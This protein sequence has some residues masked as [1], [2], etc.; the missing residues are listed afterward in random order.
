MVLASCMLVAACTGAPPEQTR[1]T[2]QTLTLGE[3]VY[4]TV[5]ENLET[6][7]ECSSEYTSQLSPHH[8][9]FVAALD[10]TLTHG[11]EGGV[12]NILGKTIQPSVANGSLPLLTDRVGEALGMLVS[13]DLDPERD[14]L[15]AMLSLASARTLFESS[16]IAS[17]ASAL[18][19]N[20]E[21]PERMHDLRR[22]AEEHDG[23]DYVLADIL[24]LA[25]PQDD[26]PPLT[27]GGINLDDVQGTLLRTQGFVEDPAYP[28]GAAAWMVRPD[29][30]GNPRVLVDSETGELAAPFTDWDG[31][32]AADVDDTGHPIDEN[33]EIID[34]PFLGKS[35]DRDPLG[36]AL[37]EHGGLLYDYY[38]VKRASMS[39]SAQMAVD[40]LEADVHHELPPLID[41]L[42]GQ[43]ATCNDGTSTCRYYPGND[44]PVA[45]LTHL[46]F[47]VLRSTNTSRLM[48]VLYTALTTD[49]VRAEDFLVAMGEVANA[50]NASTL[51]I[52]DTAFQDAII[53]LVP[54]L[55]SIFKV[56]NS[57]GQS[58]ARLLVDLLASMTPAEKAQLSASLGWMVEYQS[59]YSRPNPTPSGIRVDYD[60]PRYVGSADNRSGLEMVIEL[61]DHANCGSI[62]GRSVSY[63]I[64]DIAADLEPSTVEN[65]IGLALGGLG[66]SG[67]F[68]EVVVR[69]ALVVIGCD[70]DRTG[71]IY[72]H[73]M[74]I[75]VLAK[76]GGL[77]WLL[78][79]ARVFDDRGQIQV[80]IDIFALVAR[81]LRYDEDFSSSTVSSIR[82]LE[83][84]LVTAIKAGAL[85]KLFLAVD[86]LHEIRV[87]GTNDRATHLVVDT[88]QFIVKQ[89]PVN[90]RTGADPQNSSLAV[91]I[92]KVMKRISVRVGTSGPVYDSL[93]NL[94]G[95]G[96]R[97]LASTTR[98]G[99]R[100]LVHP[101]VRLL[102]AV[103]LKTFGD[104][105]DV[106][107]ASYA[108]YI[109][110]FQRESERFLTGRHFATLI[111]LA[112]HVVSSPNAAP[113][114][115]WLV[116]L[117]RGNPG[118]PDADTYGPIL[119]ILASAAS[120]KVAGDD[121]E[122]I[123]GWMKSV[124][125]DNR[126]HALRLVA[127]VDD[128]LAR[129]RDGSMMKVMRNAIGAGATSSGR[130]PVEVFA[131]VFADVSSVEPAN[132]CEPGG[133]MTLDRLE[134]AVEGLRDFLLDD[135][136]GITTIWKL[137][138]KAAPDREPAN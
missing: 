129:D 30:H 67:S 65:V 110:G 40:V 130:S 26:A 11:L 93:S 19:A 29:L 31:D 9:D 132:A 103:G 5:K 13:D 62:S 90:L 126:S 94:I 28:L 138:G 131:E 107:P 96:R 36:R 111:R 97:Y 54:L 35:G 46:A 20:P 24:S 33:G 118:R 49:P 8:E 80:L 6:A 113:L 84:V 92:L 73:L 76:S 120:A 34:L 7:E 74:S 127:A 71:L 50:V 1:P 3:L 52:T 15:R 78:P 18:L 64:I 100:V 44:H 37:N 10:H 108:C 89:G 70:Y 95:F 68:G 83:P 72:D 27:C 81:D 109:D 124:A 16:M 136:G 105:A 125:A 63:K 91:E 122:Q 119:Q 88:L 112:K 123:L 137:I 106:P 79:L 117:L 102:A 115:D 55:Q 2:N 86:V 104:L 22:L 25:S 21:L 128:M 85:V 53:D 133:G 61:V 12:S 116:Q 66:I 17:L 87:Q 69:G 42:L 60:E 41:A 43:P 38:D 14:T 114:E 23:V 48:D 101:N 45:D 75:D 47:E 134:E 82:R 39:F 135:S 32:G 56:S 99:R 77:D 58:T 98:G 51:A 59:L 121:L 57:D 4:R